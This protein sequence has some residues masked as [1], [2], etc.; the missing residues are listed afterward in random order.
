METHWQ[1]MLPSQEVA[2]G[3]QITDFLSKEWKLCIDPN[4]LKSAKDTE[5]ERQ[6]K[7]AQKENATLKVTETKLKEKVSNLSNQIQKCM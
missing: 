4:D 5:C 1:G 7:V 2:G 3:R 6:V